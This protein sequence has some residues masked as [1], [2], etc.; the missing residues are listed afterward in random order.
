MCC[1]GFYRAA[2]EGPMY[3]YLGYTEDEVVSTDFVGDRRYFTLWPEADVPE[4]VH[5]CAHMPFIIAVKGGV[6]V[7]QS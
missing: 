6:G 4:V 3:G 2:S 7:W 1:H 5:H